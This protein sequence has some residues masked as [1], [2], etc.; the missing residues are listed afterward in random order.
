M[1]KPNNFCWSSAFLFL[2][3]DGFIST[4]AKAAL[5]TY[6]FDVQVKNVSRLC[7]QFMLEKEIH[8]FWNNDVEEVVKQAN[9]LVLPP[10]MSDT[11]TINGKPG[12]LFPCSEKRKMRLLQ[13]SFCLQQ[14]YTMQ[15]SHVG[16]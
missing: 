13:K 10:N 12:P 2:C 4:P 15:L 5:K 1:A 7:Q 9:R 8:F 3:L 16:H 14:V 11:H 6:Q